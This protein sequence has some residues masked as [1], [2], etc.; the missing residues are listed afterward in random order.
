MYNQTL[1][2]K[3]A[4]IGVFHQV[5]HLGAQEPQVKRKGRILGARCIKDNG[6]ILPRE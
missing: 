2:G 4:Q 3:K 6:R 5:P 1:G